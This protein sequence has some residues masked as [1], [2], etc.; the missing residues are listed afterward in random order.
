VDIVAM[1]YNHIRITQ[2]SNLN[3]HTTLNTTKDTIIRC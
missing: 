3:N 1:V 2:S